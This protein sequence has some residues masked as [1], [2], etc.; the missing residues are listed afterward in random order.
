MN[1]NKTKKDE[2]GERTPL[3]VK[4]DTIILFLIL[5]TILLVIVLGISGYTYLKISSSESSYYIING[6]PFY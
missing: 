4:L 2:S 3:E 5:I 6:K 1:N